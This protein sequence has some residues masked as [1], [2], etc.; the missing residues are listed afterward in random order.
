VTNGVVRSEHR[1]YFGA[2]LRVAGARTVEMIRALLLRHSEG[3]EENG[4]ESIPAVRLHG[5]ASACSIR[6][7]P[8]DASRSPER[9]FSAA[10]SSGLEGEKVLWWMDITRWRASDGT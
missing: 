8:R 9:P 1:F 6:N 10:R 4:L 3:F 2:E 7:E 5:G